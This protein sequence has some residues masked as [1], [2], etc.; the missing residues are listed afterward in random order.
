MSIP[1]ESK[2][3]EVWYVNFIKPK[4]IVKCLI[5]N[6]CSINTLLNEQINGFDPLFYDMDLYLTIKICLY[7]YIYTHIYRYP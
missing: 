3:H 6:R 1:R 5:D 7:M 4:Q 2:C